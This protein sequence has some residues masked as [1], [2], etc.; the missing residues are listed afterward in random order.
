[1]KPGTTGWAQL[2]YPWLVPEQDATEKLQYDPLRQ[3]SRLV[4]DILIRRNRQSH[5]LRQGA[6]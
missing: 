5:P 6:R 2:C 3:E 1:V 4:F